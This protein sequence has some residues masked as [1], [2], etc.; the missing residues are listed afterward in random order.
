MTSISVKEQ[1][2][3]E[4][5]HLS[6]EQQ[7]QILEYAKSIQSVS[8]LP[9]GIPGDRLLARAQE[10]NFPAEALAEIEKAIAE[11]CERIDWDGWQ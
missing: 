1:I 6:P 3:E 10:I 11:D 4:L 8:Q 9:K 2:I 7:L 5:D